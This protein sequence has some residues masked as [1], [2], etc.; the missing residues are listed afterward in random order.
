MGAPVPI[1][2]LKNGGNYIM[3][4][5]M[6]RSVVRFQNGIIGTHVVAFVTEYGE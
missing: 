1:Y 2:R 3:G 4:L 5:C 6:E